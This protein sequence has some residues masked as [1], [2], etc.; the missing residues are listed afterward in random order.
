MIMRGF[1]S[2]GTLQWRRRREVLSGGDQ[3]PPFYGERLREELN[4]TEN[5]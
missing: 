3:R 5:D 1:S 2:L 4:L